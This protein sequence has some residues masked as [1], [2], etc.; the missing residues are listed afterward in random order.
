MESEFARLLVQ[1]DILMRVRN[2]LRDHGLHGAAFLRALGDFECV[3]TGRFVLYLIDSLS[4]RGYASMQILTSHHGFGPFT[5]YL[6]TTEHAQWIEHLPTASGFLA[7]TYVDA[8]R[9]RCPSGL[10]IELVRSIHPSPLF[11]LPHY[12]ATH[13][14]NYIAGDHLLVAYPHLTFARQGILVG[15][16][17]LGAIPA[18]L[19]T[20]FEVGPRNDLY[21]HNGTCASNHLCGAYRRRFNDNYCAV[22]GFTNVFRVEAAVN[23]VL[24]GQRCGPGCPS[25]LRVVELEAL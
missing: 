14:M 24:G 12:P 10:E 20:E 23:W 19:A 4:T 3:I 18:E 13:L 1:Y 11:L 17:T 7:G 22:I 6:L 15:D 21:H 25:G 2:T 5:Q 16:A 9:F 8:D